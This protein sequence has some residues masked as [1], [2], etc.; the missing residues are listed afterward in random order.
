MKKWVYLKQGDIIKDGDLWCGPWGDNPIPIPSSY[1]GDSVSRSD[2]KLHC[3][4][5][6]IDVND[7]ETNESKR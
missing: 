5:R 1:P 7:E 4:L 6:L 2:E 3:Y